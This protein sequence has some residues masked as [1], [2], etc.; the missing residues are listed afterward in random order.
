MRFANNTIVVTEKA[1]A[2]LN[3]S[4]DV[5]RKRE[6]GYHEMRM[7][8]QTISLH[9]DVTV[10]C[11][12]GSGQIVLKNN[13]K[14]LPTDDRNIAAKAAGVFF[15]KSG[16]GGVDTHITLHKRIPVCAGMGGGSSDGA[17]VLR[18]LNQIL[19]TRFSFETLRSMAQQLGSDVPFCVEGG[20]DLAQGR[21]EILEHLCDLPDC[22]I[23]VCKPLLSISTPRLFERIHCENLRLHPDTAGMLHALEHRDLSGVAA[24][25]YNVFE[26][27]LP[28]NAEQIHEIKSELL[29]C[30]ALGAVMTGTGSAVFGLFD[31]QRQ[32]Q[33]AY[34][35]LA[36]KYRDCF[37]T[38]NIG[39]IP[40]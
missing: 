21:G 20:T 33:Q 1:Y 38:H 15:A 4:L 16:I 3:L 17:A 2:K 6:D 22:F 35:V 12:E 28:K 9:D 14:Y 7:V 11:T 40:E 36:R 34:S 8:M 19:E 29:D 31:D 23:V 39:R 5:L 24:R 26:D 18:A 30:H 25:M 32:A 27:V 13:L 37:L 10:S